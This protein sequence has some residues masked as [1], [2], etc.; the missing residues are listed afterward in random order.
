MKRKSNCLPIINTA[1]KSKSNGTE[2]PEDLSHIIIGILF[3]VYN[4][5]GF[6]YQEKYY[7]RAIKMELLTRRLKADEQLLS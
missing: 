2:N 7:C 1:N 5:L 6:G 4:E 3:E